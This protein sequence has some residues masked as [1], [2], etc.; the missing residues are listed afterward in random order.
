M[1][2]WQAGLLWCIFLICGIGGS[3]HQQCL[4]LLC[5]N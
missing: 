5:L 1:F 4:S 2:G 3:S